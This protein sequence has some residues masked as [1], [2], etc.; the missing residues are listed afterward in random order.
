MFFVAGVS[1]KRKE[2]DYYEPILCSC[3]SKYGRYE[4][5]MEYGQLSLFFMPFLR[6]NKKYYVRTTCCNSL[7]EIT[8]KEKYLMI[9]RGQGHNVF[10]KD[11]DL[12]LIHRGTCGNICS[13]CSE[14]VS[15]GHNYCP[16]CGNKLE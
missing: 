12:E 4:G 9:V 10:L 3:C 6:F 13:N 8:N 16:N 5:F 15:E 7:Y 2:L 14:H 1:Q 11:K